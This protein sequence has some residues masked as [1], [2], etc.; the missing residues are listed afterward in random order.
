MARLYFGP[1]PIYCICCGTII[2]HNACYYYRREEEDTH[3]CFCTT[4]YRNARGGNITFNGT[5]V[6][7]TD[8]CK[9]KNDRECEE[10]VH[11]MI[12][13]YY[14][15]LNVDN[16]KLTFDF[17]SSGFNAVNAKIGSITYAHSITIEKIWTTVL[18]ISAFYAA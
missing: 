16:F 3:N 13:L 6:S 15:H 4:C 9:T 18:N 2:R 11:L 14:I 7:K 8:L 5:T 1:E 12:S 10:A 17:S